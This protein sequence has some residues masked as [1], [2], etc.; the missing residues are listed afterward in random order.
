VEQQS[1]LK[2]RQRVDISHPRMRRLKKI[3]GTLIDARQREV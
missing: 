3:D 1:V 2:R